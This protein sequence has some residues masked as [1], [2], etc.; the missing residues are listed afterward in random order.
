MPILREFAATE[1]GGVPVKVWTD[2]LEENAAQQLRAL[3]GAG[4]AV[5]HV[6]AM[7]D[8]HAGRGATVG[9]VFATRGLLLPT[10]VGADIGCGLLAQPFDLRAVDLSPSFLR[11]LHELVKGHIPTGFGQ[12]DAP[13][14]WDGF[15][16]DGRYT[17][18]VASIVRD[19]GPGQLGSLGGGNHFIELCREADVD[20]ADAW[21]WLIVHSGSR[22]AG[23][24]IAAHHIGIAR[25]LSQRLDRAAPRDLWPLPL[26]RPEGQAY[27]K[28]M[29]W[30][31]DYAAENRRRMRDAFAVLFARLLKRRLHL[32]LAFDPAK[33]INIGHNY[34]A[35]ELVNGEPLWVHR[36]GATF[37]GAGAIGVIP[38]SMATGSYIVRGLGNPAS[39]AS[40]SHGAG[41]VMSRGQAARSITLESFAKKMTGIVADLTSDYLDEAPHAYKDLDTVLH[42]QSDLVTPLQRLLPLLNIKGAGKWQ[43]SPAPAV[44]T[45][46]TAVVRKDRTRDKDDPVQRRRL[47]QRGRV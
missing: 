13:Q 37:A 1:T 33:C 15:A 26:D 44:E 30:A 42:H 17:R 31:Q 5:G 9:S 41:R 40:C 21:V 14:E 16:D 6:A 3:A 38:G 18:A 43:R 35:Q 25:D 24:L 32:D 19:K 4:Y 22:G 39:F 28:D 34:A 2:Q 20:R 23:G 11:E 29:R 7:P 46:R 47:A 45:R 12:H 36:K 10:A 27:L 8:V